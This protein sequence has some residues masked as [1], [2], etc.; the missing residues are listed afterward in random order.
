MHLKP[1][2]RLALATVALLPAAFAGSRTAQAQGGLKFINNPG[3]GQV[4]YGTIDGQ[5]TP[6]SAMGF[7][8]HQ[9]HG[10]FADRPQVS[11]VFQV[12]NS[13]SYAA[14]FTLIAK[15]DNNRAIAGEV[16]VSMPPGV[17]PIAAVLTDSAENFTHSQP[18][19]LRKLNQAWHSSNPITASAGQGGSAPAASGAMQ[20]LHRVTGGDR[21]V[22]ISVPDGWKLLS[23]AGGSVIAQGPHGE[24]L[25]L[26]TMIQGIRDPRARS[27]FGGYGNGPQVTYPFGGDLFTAYANIVNQSRRNQGLP[28][29]SFHLNRAIPLGDGA[30]EAHFDMNL[31]DGFG[32]RIATARIGE[33]GT[34]GVPTY[35]MT[36][37]GSSLPKT[38]A[39]ENDM[40]LAIIRSASQDSNV[41]RAE[42]GAVMNG[43]RAAGERSRIEAQQANDRRVASSQAFDAHMD[44][45][46]R[47][48]KSMQNY[49]LDRS[50]IQDNDQNGRATVSNG[51]ADLLIKTDPKRFEIV[52]PSQFLK[53][54]DY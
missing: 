39:S 17:Q 29:A 32:E 27:Q 24:R 34:P 50:Q 14:F 36:I 8:L 51:L 22:Y 16:I 48:S 28:P 40:L 21:S 6:Q 20:P 41:V 25:S 15:N 35:A 42:Q 23:V 54:V 49:T 18:V 33:L 30:I 53:G 7:M 4:V 26:N 2:L 3:G 13:T 46:D 9:V 38:V 5:H 52:P 12:R 47:E 43:I 19:M 10:H 11:K 44:N 45:I 1:S 31:N 37:S